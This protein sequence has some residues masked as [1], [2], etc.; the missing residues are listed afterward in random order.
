MKKILKFTASIEV[1]ENDLA[2]T[3]ESLNEVVKLFEE[4]GWTTSVQEETEE[5]K[6]K[7]LSMKWHRMRPTPEDVKTIKVTVYPGYWEDAWVN[8]KRDDADNPEIPFS[9]GDKWEIEIDRETGNIRNWPK[10]VTAKTHYKSVDQ[11]EIELIGQEGESV[12]SYDGYVP[13]FLSV[14]DSGYGDYVLIEIDGNGHIKDFNFTQQDI[15]E[16][17]GDDE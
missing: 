2:T 11:N 8:D 14:Y 17:Y 5:E 12:C 6:M 1:E 7:R 10:G 9:N 4:D 15:D 16:L 3:K 13:D